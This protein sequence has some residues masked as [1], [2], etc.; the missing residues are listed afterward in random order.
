MIR[1]LNRSEFEDAVRRTLSPTTPIRSA[2]YLRGREKKLED[3][4]RSLV[5]PGRHIFVYGDRGVGKTS[6]AQTAAY[7]HQGASSSPVC[8]GC[9][10]ASTFAQLAQELATRLLGNAP[11]VTRQTKQRK[12]TFS[13]YGIG[14]ETQRTVEQGQVGE[15]RSVNEAVTLVAYAAEKHSNTPVVIIDE[16]ERIQD[17]AQR[18]LF[19]DFIKQAGDQSVPAKFIFCGVGSSLDTLLDAHHSCYRYLTSI[20]LERLAFS[21]RLEIINRAA[22]AAS[23]QIEPSSVYRIATVSDGFPHYVH[24]ITE[25]LLWKLFDDVTFVSISTVD[26]Y[27]AAIRDA[28]Q[29]IEPKLKTSYEKATLKYSN[30][31][32][33]ESV[34]WAVADHHELKRRSLDIFDIYRRLTREAGLEPLAREKFN[35]RI[36]AL[37]GK[38]HGEIL[39]GTRQGWYSFREPVMRG[40]VRLRAEAAGVEL[41]ADHSAG[42]RGPGRL[43]QAPH[44]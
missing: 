22:D 31:D 26:H 1:A 24:L 16:F 6:L 32:E 12:G 36:N 5:Q 40:Y 13:F 19:A 44:R 7:E 21:P 14:G 15:P 43:R 29:D 42:Y 17:P 8:L 38:A 25:K 35:Q 30:R 18:M 37:K 3:I 23:V 28:V 11:T 4:R 2:E 33:Y 41:G 20:E 34:L 10:A 27:T 9:D 39:D